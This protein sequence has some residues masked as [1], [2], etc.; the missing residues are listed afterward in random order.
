[1]RLQPSCSCTRH[2]GGLFLVKISTDC[3]QNKKGTQPPE[4]LVLLKVA[5]LIV[6]E[7]D[8][9]VTGFADQ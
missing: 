7:D 1:M 4:Y 8:C 9:R 3:V 5:S 6:V 2:L